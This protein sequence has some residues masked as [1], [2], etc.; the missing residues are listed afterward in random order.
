M[1]YSIPFPRVHIRDASGAVAV[2]HLFEVRVVVVLH[3]ATI[4]LVPRTGCT[5]GTH[6]STLWLLHGIILLL[7]SLLLLL[8]RVV[9]LLWCSLLLRRRIR[10]RLLLVNWISWEGSLALVR[11]VAAVACITVSAPSTCVAAVRR[12]R[13]LALEDLRGVDDGRNTCVPRGR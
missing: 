6:T 5:T 13:V 2:I 1:F 7:V 12:G 11:V 3:T 9:L 4:V 8:H 10:R